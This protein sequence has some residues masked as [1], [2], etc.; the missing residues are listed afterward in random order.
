MFPPWRFKL[1]EAQVALEQGR[2]EEA[3]KIAGQPE[4][5]TYLPV[6]QL[7]VEIGEQLARRAWERAERSRVLNE[8]LHAAVAAAD[9]TKVAAVANQLLEI[10]PENR[11]ARDARMRAWDEVGAPVGDSKRLAETQHWGGTPSSSQTKSMAT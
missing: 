10:S 9:W 6:Q 8:Q 5:R 3:A 11:V 1:R 7:V 2:L 4:V